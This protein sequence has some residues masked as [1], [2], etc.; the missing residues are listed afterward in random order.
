MNH[1]QCAEISHSLYYDWSQGIPRPPKVVTIHDMIHER[2]NVGKTLRSLKKRAVA[3]ADC[4]I[5]ISK[6]TA[7][8][9]RQFYTSAPVCVVIPPGLSQTIID[10]PKRPLNADRR[11]L[12]YVG[13]RTGYK[14]F[15]I[16]G[17]AI[18]RLAR[19]GLS[20]VLVGGGK[21]KP[22]EQH[23]LR[24]ALGNHS[25]VT[26][27]QQP[28]DEELAHLYDGAAATV[29]TSRYEGF[30][31]PLLEAMAHGCPVA[32]SNSGSLPEVSAGHAEMFNAD[33]PKACAAAIER[34]IRKEPES[35][36][37]AE[38]YARTHTWERSARQ[39]TQLYESLVK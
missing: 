15:S 22:S 28:D 21:L 5:A 27:A 31:L 20:L 16:L 4:L 32:S 17:D 11:Y 14:N 38:A 33:D 12:L 29:V 10:L 1:T 8:D 9:V 6:T 2:F 3:Q 37:E 7:N 26:H 19:H 25:A 39:H 13:P 35:L 30:G 24:I 23:A 18:P 34:A 36:R